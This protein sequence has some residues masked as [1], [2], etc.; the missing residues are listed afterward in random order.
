MTMN[1]CSVA[2]IRARLLSR[3]WVPAWLAIAG[4]TI[5]GVTGFAAENSV[6]RLG[7]GITAW[8]LHDYSSAT[9][10]LRGLQVP[11]VPDYGAYYLGYAELLS[12]SPEAAV[13]TLDAYRTKP[14][15]SSPLAGRIDVVHARALINLK[16]PATLAKAIMGD[17]GCS[18][19]SAR[20]SIP[21]AHRSPARR[22]DP[23]TPT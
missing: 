15:Q 22:A 9:Q 1:V 20:H 7:R 3:A 14:A 21:T 17:C 19:A 12:G 11:K 5:A 16:Q 2:N 4:V 8:D 10:S 6:N 23:P 18:R 13:R